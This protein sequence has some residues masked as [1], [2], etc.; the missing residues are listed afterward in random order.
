ME[1]DLV[2]VVIATYNRFSYLMNTI[3]SVKHQTYQNIEIIVV[4]DCSTQKEYYEYDFSA[5]GIKII[6]L[7]KNSK[8]IHGFAC[9][10]GYQ[11]NF[12]IR[13]A[14]GQFIAFCDDDDIWFPHKVKM[15]VGLLKLTGC[16]ICS[17]EAICGNGVFVKGLEYK[18][19]NGYQAKKAIHRIYNKSKSFIRTPQNSNFLKTGDLDSV[20]DL[21]FLEVNN[22]CICSSVMIEKSIIDKVGFFKSMSTLDDYEYWLRVMKYTNCIYIS[23]PCVYYDMGHG[24]GQNFVGAIEDV[25]NK[26]VASKMNAKMKECGFILQGP[27]PTKSIP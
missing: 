10:G 2:S 3:A 19:Y 20:W 1:P 17:T 16:G 22:C 7:E 15:Q 27:T 11:R 24:D 14:K 6:H 13:V 9:P 25:E 23:K 18:L 12:G 21:N 5:N 26:E 4:N 8:Q